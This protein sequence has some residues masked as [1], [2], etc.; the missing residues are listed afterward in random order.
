[1]V[2]PADYRVKVESVRLQVSNSSEQV[3]LNENWNS[4]D[5]PVNA[6]DLW[7]SRYPSTFEIPR[8]QF[9]LD[10][11]N[12]EIRNDLRQFLSNSE[13]FQPKYNLSLVEERELALQRL[14]AICNAPIIDGKS[15]N[16]RRFISVKDFQ[17]NPS[18]IFATH[19]IAGLADGSMATKMTVQFNLFGG[20]V[21]HLGVPNE[22]PNYHQLLN[23]IDSLN[24]LGCF[25]LTELGYG[26]NAVEMETTATYIP[27]QNA[28]HLLTPNALAQ[29]YWITNAAIHAHFC[30]VFAQLMIHEK[31]YGVHAFL[32][33]IRDTVTLAPLDGVRIEDMGVKMGCNG[34]DNGKLSFD[35]MIPV[36]SLLSK[37][38]Q[39]V[40][41]SNGNARFESKIQGIRERFLRVTDQLLSGRLCIAAM[42][43]GTS[44][45]ALTIAVR[46]SATRMCVG[47]DTRSSMS[48]LSFQ[49][50]QNA[51]GPLLAR[52]FASNAALNYCKNAYSKELLKKDGRVH[53]NWQ[54]VVILC[55]A[56]KPFVTWNAE[57]CVRICRER[58]G[59][60]G[61]L[62]AN[63]FGSL[64]G[65]CHAGLTAEG[66]NSV[67]MQ[68]VAK[69]LLTLQSKNIDV[70][71]NSQFTRVN[72]SEFRVGKLNW[73]DE[74]VQGKI[75][76][77]RQFLFGQKLAKFSAG[78][79]A[80][81]VFEQWMLRNNG[82]VQK[83]AMAFAERLG[84]ES[85]LEMQ[86]QPYA[87]TNNV[88]LILKVI[89]DL[90][91]ID[92]VLRDIA[93]FVS[94]GIVKPD[95]IQ[96]LQARKD[97][98]CAKIGT[99]LPHLVDAFGIPEK[100]IAAPIAAD[101]VAYNEHDNQGEHV[102]L[103]YQS[104]PHKL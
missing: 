94:H 91:F 93:F 55:C 36:S 46:Y 96:G 27:Q 44:K 33:Q 26:N 81:E 15:E 13:L 69:E 50:Q 49:L 14:S 85:L 28:F 104:K 87:S 101:W 51:F 88:R 47:K 1:M 32:V 72:A 17:S 62:S 29:K 23:A 30:V 34:V 77:L 56:V 54:K 86:S 57:E 40:V 45:L 99:Q 70:L 66:D 25:G 67:L 12:H 24:I 102:A 11:D 83:Y 7:K 100:L 82:I 78:K 58:C 59:G 4:R 80:E 89:K 37:Y 65:F 16:E 6:R 22:I 43:L 2:F 92:C 53:E 52:V 84:W 38:S 3:Q 61:Y 39:V 76:A 60:Q 48:I 90:Y 8:L 21:L 103:A 79:G 41:E 20:T 98:L 74:S 73:M 42:M 97:E 19:E 95:E 31:R 35:T 63:R 9:L 5:N 64:I 68:K 75:M 71:E 18:R 10:G